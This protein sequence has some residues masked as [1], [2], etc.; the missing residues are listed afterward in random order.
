MKFTIERDDPMIIKDKE[1]YW[2]F[3]L[4]KTVWILGLVGMI[5]GF[6]VEL[7]YGMSSY[8]FFSWIVGFIVVYYLIS[9][10]FLYVFFGD[11]ILET[12]E[13]LKLPK[14]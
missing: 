4:L 2:W 10:I 12:Y 6:I 13:I 8:D 11:P 1:D 9:S 7:F 5:I 3:R 14:E